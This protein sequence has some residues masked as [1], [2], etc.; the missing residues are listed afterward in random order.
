MKNYIN[1]I[2]YCPDWCGSVVECQPMNQ[3]VAGSIPSQGACLGAGQVLSRGHVTGNRTLMFLSLSF[4]LLP[5][6]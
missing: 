1:I 2:R 5:P 3:R 6:L 4:S